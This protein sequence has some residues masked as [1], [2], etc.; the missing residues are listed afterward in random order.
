MNELLMGIF[1][2]LVVLVVVLV[3]AG[4]GA[5]LKSE[6]CADQAISDKPN[7]EWRKAVFAAQLRKEARE[8][9]KNLP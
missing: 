7:I 1:Y 4:M 3:S 2:G 9:S 5:S 6:K 8:A